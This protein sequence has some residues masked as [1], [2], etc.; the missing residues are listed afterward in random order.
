MELIIFFKGIFGHFRYFFE[1][2]CYRDFHLFIKDQ[3]LTH[4]IVFHKKLPH[5]ASGFCLNIFSINS[6]KLKTHK[7]L[8]FN[9][10]KTVTVCQLI[11]YTKFVSEHPIRIQKLNTGMFLH[12]LGSFENDWTLRH[13][14]HLWT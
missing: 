8:Q 10:Q 12:W 13:H 14:P 2:M 1:K 4:L 5:H 11:S 6:K 3:S 7:T 9:W